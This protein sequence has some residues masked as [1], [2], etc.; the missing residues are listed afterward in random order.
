MVQILMKYLLPRLK[1]GNMIEHYSVGVIFCY[2]DIDKGA[3]V[4]E[5]EL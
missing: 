3:F 1:H 2:F 5:N 4:L